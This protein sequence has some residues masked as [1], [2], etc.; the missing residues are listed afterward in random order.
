MSKITDINMV[1]A[2][3]CGPLDS[4]GSSE[5]STHVT[6]YFNILKELHEKS[7]DPSIRDFINVV[8]KNS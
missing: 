8:E 5:V 7:K 4:S 2:I 3:L 6:K 1:A